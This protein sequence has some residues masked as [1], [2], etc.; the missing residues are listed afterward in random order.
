MVLTTLGFGPR[1]PQ[2]WHGRG[3]EAAEGGEEEA[4]LGQ[5]LETPKLVSGEKRL[6]K[7]KRG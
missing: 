6:T 5:N 7:I 2:V 3:S 4:Y 1:A